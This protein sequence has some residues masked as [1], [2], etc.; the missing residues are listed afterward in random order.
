MKKILFIV[1]SFLVLN[2]SLSAQK[3]ELITVKAGNKIL[4]YF[5]VPVRYRYPEFTAGQVIFK[6]GAVNSTRLNYNLLID[7]IEFIQS[8]DTLSLVK[9]KDIRLIVVAQDTFFFD[10]GYLEQIYGGRVKVGLRQRIELKEVLKKDSYGTSSSGSASNSYDVLPSDGNFYKLT[11]NEDMV[12]QKTKEYYVS[13]GTSG[14]VQLRKKSLLQ[15][16]PQKTNEIQKYLKSNKVDFEKHDD[17]I[18]LADYLS[19]F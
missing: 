1:F 19:T 8:R 14:F 2:T 4:D 3:N 17:I 7:E 18:R 15:L 9:K 16:F 12:F 11:P 13:V 5:P 10:N 6:N